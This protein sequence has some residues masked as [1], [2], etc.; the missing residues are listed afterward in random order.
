MEENEMITDEIGDTL[1]EDGVIDESLEDDAQKTDK[2][3]ETNDSQ[4]T[5]SD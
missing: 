1:T 5:D 3:D 2:S 4:P